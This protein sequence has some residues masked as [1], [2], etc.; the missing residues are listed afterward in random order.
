MI[1]HVSNDRGSVKAMLEGNGDGREHEWLDFEKKLAFLPQEVL[2]ERFRMQSRYKRNNI[3]N[4]YA[5]M[6]ILKFITAL[7]IFTIIVA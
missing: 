1:D 3:E 5:Y 7:I 2:R 4:T 6:R